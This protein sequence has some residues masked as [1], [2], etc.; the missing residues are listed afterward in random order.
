[1]MSQR[2]FMNFTLPV[3]SASGKALFMKSYHCN[4]LSPK[5]DRV[6]ADMENFETLQPIAFEGKLMYRATK[7][8][9]LPVQWNDGVDV[10][11]VKI[12]WSILVDSTRID[13]VDTGSYLHKHVNM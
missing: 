6:Y 9:Y 11:A 1:M 4:L 3:K 2:L 8:M 10:A 7:V 12:I 13:N 5:G